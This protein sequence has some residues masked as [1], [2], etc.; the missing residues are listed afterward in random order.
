LLGALLGLVAPSGAR[1]VEQKSEEAAAR[2]RVA[3]AEQWAPTIFQEVKD[4]RDYLAAFD[5]DGDW[6]LSNNAEHVDKFPLKAVVYYT[7]AE[8]ASHWIITY[9]PYHPVDA[10]RPSGHDHDTEHVTLVVR[11]AGGPLGELE[12]METRF[13]HTYYQ[14]AAP[15]ARVLDGA[16]DVD[17]PIHFDGEHPAIHSQRV[18]HGLCGGHA[19][20]AWFDALALECDH[21]EAPRVGRGV[22]YRWKGRAEQPRSSD[23]RD[24]GYALVE[25]GES[26]WR[27]ARELGPHATFAKTMSFDGDRCRLFRCPTGIGSV[28]AAATGHA[29]TGALWEESSGRGVRARG[30]AFFDPAYTLSRRLRFAAPF[31]LDYEW[32]PYLGIGRFATH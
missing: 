18:G 23:D 7:V 19:P 25:I 4:R 32:N 12:A 11:K 6:D 10:K 27:H 8:T 9:L 16:D 26:L 28:L 1:A 24:V 5:F 22:V 15:G 2:K 17:G 20:T 31:S 3:V 29:S 13:H 14:Y 21:D 30:E